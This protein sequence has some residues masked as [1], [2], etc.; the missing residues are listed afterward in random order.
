MATSMFK[1]YNG[2]TNALTAALPGVTTGTTTIKSMLQIAP[3]ATQELQVKAWGISFSGTAADN[4]IKCELVEVDVAATV[5][6]HVAG[7]IH[8]V[9][10]SAG[11]LASQVT[12]STTTTGY[13]ASA[14]GTITASRLLDFDYVAPTSGSRIYLNPLGDEWVVQPSKFL[15]VRITPTLTTAVNCVCWVAWTEG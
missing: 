8:K 12:L 14:E 13:T 7:S 3:P 10:P 11:G 2:A 1:C 9:G 6:A 4:P 5:T 15:R